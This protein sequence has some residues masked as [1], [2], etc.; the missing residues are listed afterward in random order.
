LIPTLFFYL[1]PSRS[2]NEDN[3][4][5]NDSVYTDE[6]LPLPYYGPQAFEKAKKLF[7]GFITTR[8][9]MP[10]IQQEKKKK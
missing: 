9:T 6:H 3:K 2:A 1:L 7:P 4:Q 5:L 10:E 8:G